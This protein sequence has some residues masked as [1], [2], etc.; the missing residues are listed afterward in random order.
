MNIF[1]QKQPSGWRKYGGNKHPPPMV[2]GIRGWGE[3]LQ[4]FLLIV[5]TLFVSIALLIYNITVH[6][7]LFIASFFTYVYA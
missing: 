5:P 3:L 7:L 4:V 1:Y 6:I 2:E